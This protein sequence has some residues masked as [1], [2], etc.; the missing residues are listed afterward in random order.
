MYEDYTFIINAR[1]HEHERI[2]QFGLK[3]I[4]FVAARAF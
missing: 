1:Y 4:Y 3:F 2:I